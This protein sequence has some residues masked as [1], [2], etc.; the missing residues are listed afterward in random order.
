MVVIRLG[1]LSHAYEKLNTFYVK[2]NLRP[3]D[4]A[5]CQMYARVYVEASAMQRPSCRSVGCTAFVHCSFKMSF[6]VYFVGI[7]L[8]LILN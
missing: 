2:G 6:P 5:A 8:T 3:N 1:H 4:V 7:L